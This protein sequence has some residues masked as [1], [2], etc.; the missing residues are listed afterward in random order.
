[1]INY[2]FNFFNII[3]LQN[4]CYIMYIHYRY[5]NKYSYTYNTTY[6]CMYVYDIK[7]VHFN[8]YDIINFE[9]FKIKY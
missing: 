5:F 6:L 2:S 3:L 7:C 4:I 1:M 8:N 9:Y